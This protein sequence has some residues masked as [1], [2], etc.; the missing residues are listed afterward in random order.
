MKERDWLERLKQEGE[1]IPVPENL[2]PEAVRQML[3]PRIRE[4]A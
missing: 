4:G 1:Q 2:E 3:D